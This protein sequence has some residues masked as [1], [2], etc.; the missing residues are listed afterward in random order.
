VGQRD[1]VAVGSV[2]RLQQP[3]TQ[4]RAGLVERIATGR[5]EGALRK[6]TVRLNGGRTR[7]SVQPEPPA[8]IN[9]VF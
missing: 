6:L 8:A 2:P 7:A 4:T 5:S 9:A 1:D 3:A